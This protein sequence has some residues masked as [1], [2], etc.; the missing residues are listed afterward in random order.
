M[1]EIS[2]RSQLDYNPKVHINNRKPYTTRDLEFIRDTNYSLA[3]L[4]VALGRTAKAI[5]NQRYLIKKRE[6]M[7][8]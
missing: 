8:E 3:D 7:N 6:G 2:Y 1:N 4:A 5:A